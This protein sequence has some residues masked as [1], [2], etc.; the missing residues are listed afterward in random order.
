MESGV[1]TGAGGRSENA[2]VAFLDQAL[3]KRLNADGADGPDP[4]AWLALQCGMVE[5][6]EQGVLLLG[7][8]D[9]GPYAPAAHWPDGRAR[10]APLTA[11]AELCLAERRGVAQ[12]D[13]AP[14]R[15]HIAYPLLV[16]DQLL[17][18]VALQLGGIPEAHLR[19]AMRQ[20]QWGVAWMETLQRRRMAA[21]EEG[22]VA[23][24]RTALELVARSV[25]ASRFQAACNTVVT[26]LAHRLECER[27]G[28]GFLR[29]GHTVLVALS[30]S[31]Q[32]SGRMN[33]IR[34]IEGAMDETCTQQEPV[35]YPA[36]E[37]DST[38]VTREH[39]RLVES[40]G[41][42]AAYSVPLFAAGEVVG[43]L[44]FERG[45][46]ETFDGETRALCETSAALLGP[47]LHE[48]RLNDRVVFVKLAEAFA[49]QL[50]RLFGPRYLG[51]KL[52]LAALVLMTVFFTFA[53]GTYRVTAPAALEG[54]IQRA[55]AAP[56]DGYIFNAAVRAGDTVR[57]GQLLA[58]LDT[59]DLLLE[60][61]RWLSEQ[62]QKSLEYDQALAERQRASVHIIEAQMEQA[63][64]QVALIDEQLGRSRLVAPFD[65]IVISGDLS[66]SIGAAVQRG[67]VLFE[68]APL[69]AYRVVLEVDEREIDEIADGQRG[70]LV[71]ST[72]PA[73]P[74]A[75]AVE[76]ITPVS[77]AR[78]GRNFFRV[79][80]RLEDVSARLR[81]GMEGIGKV[82]VGTRNLFWIWTHSLFDWLRLRL[83]SLWP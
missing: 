46:G 43:A 74:F 26:D 22:H 48:K 52:A 25:E 78:E 51:R 67:E 37:E 54:V 45:A 27:V 15:Y 2:R 80:G 12:G 32:F 38:H 61:Q 68:L 5:G 71:V 58:E 40:Y 63:R 17:G 34:A 29:R 28:I 4:A 65:A 10:S 18:V 47:I 81:P 31:T 19:L 23:R 73:S 16:D 70:T 82:A 11:A 9:Q 44:T 1:Q 64:A 8:A 30:H 77:E 3:W 24:L 6:V 50:R 75:F 49:I 56:L 21:A 59:H 55:V 7:P 60:R 33:L 41:A 62:R 36:A 76:K 69:D 83:W 39:A 72:M 66:Q 42:G 57:E 13:G 20:L 79:E 35:L 14:G 53:T